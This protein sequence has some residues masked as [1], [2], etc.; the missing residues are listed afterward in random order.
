[1]P[2]LLLRL[3]FGDGLTQAA[4]GLLLLGAAMTLLA[5]SY[6]AVQYMVALG[7]RRFLWM[8]AAIAL[9]EPVILATTERDIVAFAAVVFGVQCV[10]AASV[11]ALGLHTRRWRTPAVP[12]SPV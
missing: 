3:A 8:L 11:L 6:L 1:M 4:G 10:A 2:D 9:A 5:V 7:E 12:E